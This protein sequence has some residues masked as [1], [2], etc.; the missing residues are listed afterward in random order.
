[1]Q[2]VNCRRMEFRFIPV[3][4]MRRLGVSADLEVHWSILVSTMIA[5]L[6]AP[7][8]MYLPHVCLTQTLL[9]IPCPGC[10]IL[11]AVKETV[12]MH[13][14]AAALSNPAGIVLV[15]VIGSQVLLQSGAIAFAGIR[16]K[17]LVL[18]RVMSNVA[19]SC[20]L[21]VWILRLIQGGFHVSYYLSKM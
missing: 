5:A 17:V 14:K 16:R 19:L 18:S 11:H 20:L 10:G 15:L 9:G 21:A 12:E 7:V 8:L 3:W 2:T 1:M 13:F 6:M 4:I